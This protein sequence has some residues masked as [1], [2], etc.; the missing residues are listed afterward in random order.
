MNITKTIAAACAAV[1]LT[2]GSAQAVPITGDIDFAGQ[3]FFNTNSLATATQVVNF[4]SSGGVNASADVTDAT[5]SFATTISM[6]DLA[7]FPNGYQF[8]PSA[9]VSPLWTVGGFTFNLTSSTIVLQNSRFLII[10]GT[11][12]LT[13]PPGFDPTFGTWAF[14]SQQSDGGS[15][16]SFSFS[17]NTTG[18]GQ[19]PDGGSTVALLGAALVG[20]AA[21]RWKLAT[22]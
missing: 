22:A 16:D 19:V 10:E 4:R 12:I 20:M 5:G 14:T 9:A 17:A 18:A 21:L 6:G 13:G 7:S 8:N 11:G 15:R 1:A 3:A 2:L